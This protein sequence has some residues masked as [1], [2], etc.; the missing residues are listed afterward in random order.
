MRETNSKSKYTCG[1]CQESRY[2][3]EHTANLDLPYDLADD[4]IRSNPDF[5]KLIDLWRTS[6][7]S[8]MQD[9]V[10][11]QEQVRETIREAEREREVIRWA[12]A[13]PLRPQMAIGLR[14]FVQ[15]GRI[16]AIA[17]CSIISA[18]NTFHESSGTL[19]LPA[20]LIS[21][22]LYV[23]KDYTST[24]RLPQG[25][26]HNNYLRPVNWVLSS[27]NP[28]DGNLLVI[29][30]PFEANALIPEIRRSRRVTLHVYAP[31]ISKAC[32]SFDKLDFYNIPP[33]PE[34][35]S[36]Q[37][38]WVSFGCLLDSYTS[39]L[40]TN[41]NS[42]AD[43]SVSFPDWKWKKEEMTSRFQWT[44]LSKVALGMR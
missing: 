11:Q 7:H 2:L 13:E 38:N 5:A 39:L 8:G 31:K 18:F 15:T 44:A 40:S 19:Y 30:S 42:S 21:C 4:G 23:T 41:T 22:E 14:E 6:G 9:L 12:K 26:V 24:V 36:V 20:G 37:F 28:Q 33:T 29:I 1:H 35:A 25:S 16:P 34:K 32:F 3:G 17:G 10:L 43:T 27:N